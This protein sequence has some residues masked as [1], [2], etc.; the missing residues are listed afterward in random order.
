MVL[1]HS[2]NKVV[3][4]LNETPDLYAIRLQASSQLER[5]QVKTIPLDSTGRNPATMGD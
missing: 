2:I 1:R 5:M 4:L 3:K